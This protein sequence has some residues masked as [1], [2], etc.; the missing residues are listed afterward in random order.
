MTRLLPLCLL[1]LTACMP[2]APGLT[3]AEE[4]EIR[5]YVPD[6]D[7]SDLTPAQAGAL[8]SALHHGDGFDIPAQIRSILMW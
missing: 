1:L 2:R 6:A 4:Y 5:R 3:A 8:S 7:L